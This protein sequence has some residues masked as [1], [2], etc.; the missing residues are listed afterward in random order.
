ML[1]AHNTKALDL[2]KDIPVILEDTVFQHLESMLELQFA[3][4]HPLLDSEGESLR[5]T[6][7]E[8][9]NYLHDCI[10]Y[11]RAKSE[12]TTQDE[13][14]QTQINLWKQLNNIS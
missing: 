8:W 12:K 13:Q 7:E 11:K 10:L 2:T 4:L 9:L 14:T 1:H 5:Y 3:K 6:T